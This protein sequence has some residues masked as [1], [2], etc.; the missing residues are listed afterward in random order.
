L[1]YE[2]SDGTLL[3]SSEALPY[4]DGN[5]WNI[6][7]ASGSQYQLYSNQTNGSNI[8]YYEYLHGDMNS[9][10]WESN[11]YLYIGSGSFVGSIQEFR[12]W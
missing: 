8:N 4:F 12:L 2:D 6:L 5:F 9:E 7:I 10:S 11:D 1:V 3:S